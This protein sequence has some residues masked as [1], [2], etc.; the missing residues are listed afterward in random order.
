MYRLF[1]WVLCWCRVGLVLVSRRPCVGFAFALPWLGVGLCWP[2]V[3][4]RLV[5]IAS[6][7]FWGRGH[8]PRPPILLHIG[9]GFVVGVCWPCVCCVLSVCSFR[10]GFALAWRW[11]RAGPP[12]G[13]F[14]CWCGLAISRSPPRI[15]A[16]DRA[17]HWCWSCSVCAGLVLVLRWFCVGVVLALCWRRGGGP[18]AIAV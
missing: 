9:V 4:G 13:S 15:A 14:C 1:V 18:C 6:F 11:P 17:W 2:C 5:S 8:A 16:V 3:W 12:P 7:R 10:V